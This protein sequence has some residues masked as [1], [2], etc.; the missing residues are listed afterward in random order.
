VLTV[1]ICIDLKNKTKKKNHSTLQLSL[2]FV[3]ISIEHLKIA[4][5]KK[6]KI[7]SYTFYKLKDLTWEIG[8]RVNDCNCPSP[9]DPWLP[10]DTAL[11]SWLLGSGGKL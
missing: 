2:F 5:V 7:V 6:K 8:P 11:P 1:N 3:D 9:R 4:P 10:S